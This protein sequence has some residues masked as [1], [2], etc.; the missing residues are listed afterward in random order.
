MKEALEV[1]GLIVSLVAG[2]L[3]ILLSMFTVRDRLRTESVR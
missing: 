2:L 1:A 3:G